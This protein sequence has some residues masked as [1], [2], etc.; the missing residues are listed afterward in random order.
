MS[1][2]R[3]VRVIKCSCKQ[4]N[5]PRPIPRG[6]HGTA[7][8]VSSVRTVHQLP[9]P[10]CLFKSYRNWYFCQEGFICM[11]YCVCVK[12]FSRASSCPS[13]RQAN[14]AGTMAFGLA[15]LCCWELGVSGPLSPSMFYVQTTLVEVVPL[16][17]SLRRCCSTRAPSST[18]TRWL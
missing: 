16:G 18:I 12:W 5:T 2:N 8:Y 10:Q 17:C 9:L 3:L 7:F 4:P 1:I 13:K 11:F 6:V 14:H 15:T